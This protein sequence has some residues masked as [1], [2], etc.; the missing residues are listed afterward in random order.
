VITKPY[1]R[2]RKTEALRLEKKKTLRFG[3]IIHS[4]SSAAKG[5]KKKTPQYLTVHLELLIDE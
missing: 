5:D 3:I 2:A 1:A 4:V